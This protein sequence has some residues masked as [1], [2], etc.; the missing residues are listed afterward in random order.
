MEREFERMEK[1]RLKPSAFLVQTMATIFICFFACQTGFVCAWPSGTIENFKSNNTVLSMPMT[2]FEVSLLGSLL[3]IGALIVTPFCAYAFNNFGRKYASI[4]FGLPFVINWLIISLTK[5]VPW[6]LIAITISGIGIGGQNASVIFISEIVHN[7]IRGGLTA[8][9][10]SGYLLG[11]L[12]GYALGGYLSYYQVIYANMAMAITSMGLLMLLPESPVFLVLVGKIEEAAKSIAFYNRLDPTS[13]EV[14]RAIKNI[15][16]QLDPRLEMMLEAEQDPEVI[17]RLL[18]VTEDSDITVKPHTESAW[19]IL[20]GSKSSKRALLV[21]LVLMGSTIMMGCPVIQVYAEPLFREAVPTMSPNQCSILLAANFFVASITCVGV[22]DRCGRKN[23]MLGSSL[24]SGICLLL[25]GTQ[26]QF[27]WAS[28]WFTVVLIYAFSFAFTM[29]CGVIPQ[30]LNGEIFLP[31]VRSLC[32][33]MVLSSQCVSMFFE[34]L[35]FNLAVEVIGMGPVFYCFSAICFFVTVFS[36]IALPETKG[37]ST[38]A[39]QALFL[40]KKA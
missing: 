39:I 20:R 37:L 29:G 6:I 12:V 35:V 36:C 16:I 18:T 13:K 10:A 31:E 34:L 27:Q 8:L 24:A 23:L 32:T 11:L 17:D 28:P 7:S 5:S 1:I 2:T 26:L 25:L 40:K 38:D 15:R 22:I 30:V 4:L 14:D 3:N 21:N 33:N 9:S 19:K